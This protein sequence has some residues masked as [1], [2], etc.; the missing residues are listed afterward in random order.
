VFGIGYGELG[1]KLGLMVA[2]A[3]ISGAW[4]GGK[5][6]DKFDKDRPG[7]SLRII[8]ATFLLAVPCTFA[9]VNAANIYLSACSV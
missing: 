1:L 3:G 4:L 9:A 8:T 5:V 7:A 6:G 2:I